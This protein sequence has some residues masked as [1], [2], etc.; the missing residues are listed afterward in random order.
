MVVVSQTVEYRDG[1]FHELGSMWPADCCRA[2]ARILF[3]AVGWIL[4]VDDNFRNMCVLLLKSL[5][6]TRHCKSILFDPCLRRVCKPC[7]C[8]SRAAAQHSDQC[9][10]YVLSELSCAREMHRN[11]VD[12]KCLTAHPLGKRRE[13][14]TRCVSSETSSGKVG[15]P[16]HERLRFESPFSPSSSARHGL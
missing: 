5:Q 14:R 15:D 9:R 16:K 1:P 6:L 10:L 4:F 2:I 12:L 13:M 7:H 8:I 3:R 11:N